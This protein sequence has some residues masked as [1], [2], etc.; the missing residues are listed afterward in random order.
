MAMQIDKTSDHHMH[1]VY[2]DGDGSIDDMARAAIDKGLTQIT[3]TDHMPLP[4]KTRYAMQRAKIGAYRNE[5]RQT[6]TAYDGHLD[7][8]SGLEFE[9]I[10]QYRP[11]I[12]DLWKMGW[13]DCIV[14]VHRLFDGDI[15]G[16]VN[17][18]RKE[19]DALLQKA[20][21]DIKTLCRVYYGVI[22]SA[23]RTGWFDTVG[24]L[25]V[26]KKHNADAIFFDDSDAWY[27][28]LVMATLKVIKDSGMKMEI[29]T[30]GINHPA[31][32][33]YPS[34]WIAHEAAAMDIPMVLGS[35]SHQSG[36]VGQYFDSIDE[37]YKISNL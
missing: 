9:F 14:S 21:N 13:D 6:R 15:D 8:K 34:P 1:S 7:I 18:T 11:W 24:H 25:D 3:I 37:V 36:T 10:Q 4:F 17:G 33:P 31:R 30:A 26:I 22:Q 23:C 19:F 29:N 16:M 32:V 5:I 27:R 12:H 28:G 2:S 20:N 35:D